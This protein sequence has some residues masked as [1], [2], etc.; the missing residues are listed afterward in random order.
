MAHRSVPR[1]FILTGLAVFFLLTI[2][3]FRQSPPSPEARAPGHI[4]KSLPNLDISESML[5]GNTIMPELGNQTAKAELGRS[6]WRLLHTMMGR[7]PDEPSN[8]EQET[9]RSYLYLFARLYPCGECA[10]HFSKLLKK[11][12]PQVS[13]RSAAAG[14][15]CMVHNEVNKR[16][17]KEIFDCNKIGDFYDCGCSADSGPPNSKPSKGA[18]PGDARRELDGQGK[19][20]LLAVEISDEP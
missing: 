13:S 11:F 10:A 16:L 7:F 8:E 18:L 5:R 19:G 12:P 15:A 17:K 6:S 2:A 20:A 1:I 9:L 14:W 4:W 3:F